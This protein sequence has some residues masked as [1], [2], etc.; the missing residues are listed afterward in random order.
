MT[1]IDAN[2]EAKIAEFFQ[3]LGINQ[4]PGDVQYRIILRV[5]EQN[6]GKIVEFS[7]IRRHTDRFADKGSIGSKMKNVFQF[8]GLVK[9]V[10]RGG[11]T[12]T[13]RGMIAAD[14]L[15]SST[16]YYKKSRKLV[17]MM[18]RLP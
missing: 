17:E 14:F 18:E 7:E 4:G 1:D 10:K 16:A 3:S 12:I 11:Y 15:E 9:K 2:L 6:E 8:A 13:D 5:M